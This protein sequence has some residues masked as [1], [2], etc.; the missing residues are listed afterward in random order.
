M[1]IREVNLSSY[2][3]KSVVSWYADL[4]D[5]TSVEKLV[6]EEHNKLSLIHI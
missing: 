6:F 2:N 4:T 5:L 3:A 1:E